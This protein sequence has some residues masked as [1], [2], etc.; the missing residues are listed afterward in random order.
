MP[1]RD[2]VC[3]NEACK[4][5]FEHLWTSFSREQEERPTLKCPKCGSSELDQKLAMSTS[6]Q[7]HGSGWT[8]KLNPKRR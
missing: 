3:K 2:Y 7:L 4:H 6:F 1:I 8:G 5:E